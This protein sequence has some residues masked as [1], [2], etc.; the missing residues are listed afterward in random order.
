MP[1]RI[2]PFLACG[3]PLFSAYFVDPGRSTK[4]P[5]PALTKSAPKRIRPSNQSSSM[6][7]VVAGLTPEVQD[8]MPWAA[9]S[10]AD[11]SIWPT[12]LLRRLASR[13]RSKMS[14]GSRHGS[15]RVPA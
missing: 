8:Q 15:F 9:V 5:M 14:G 4:K 2:T 13:R 1:A 3:I 10:P 6:R 12:S 7:L 11:V